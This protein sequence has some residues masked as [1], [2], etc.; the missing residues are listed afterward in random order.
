MKITKTAVWASL[1]TAYRRSICRRPLFRPTAVGPTAPDRR[2]I[3]QAPRLD[4]L[5]DGGA[6]SRCRASI[7]VAHRPDS[8]R[9]GCLRATSSR[10]STLSSHDGMAPPTVSSRS[11][12]R[13]TPSRPRSRRG[14]RP[15]SGDLKSR[16]RPTPTV[17]TT[18]ERSGRLGPSP[19]IIPGNAADRRAARGA[20]KHGD[21]YRITIIL[22][23]DYEPTD[24]GPAHDHSGRRRPE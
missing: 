11:T 12:T 9:H 15:A 2:E 18:H 14:S 20:A 21:L 13:P 23:S 1:S 10:A 19:A 4:P 3:L 5:S 24:A 22:S 6:R 16:R 17:S 7:H 8:R